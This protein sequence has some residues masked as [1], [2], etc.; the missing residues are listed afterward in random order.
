[1]NTPMPPPP[2]PAPRPSG[3]PMPPGQPLPPTRAE[4]TFNSALQRPAAERPAYLAEACADDDALHAEVMA[5]LQAH[6]AADDFMKTDAPLS[7]EIEEQL[8]RLKPEAEG[9]RIGRYKLL[10]EIGEGG[11]GTVWMAEQMEPV[12]RRVALK[13]IKMGMDTREVI[14]RFESERQALAMMDHPNIA[15][16]FDAG[17]TQY[18]RPF[19]VM[20]LVK[21]VTITQYCDGAQL[22]TRERLAL[23][24]DVCSAINHAHQKGVIHRD[25]K[26]SNV[27]VTLHGDKPV[28][29]VI[30]FG[31]AK[32]TQGKLTDKTL[33]TRF[34]Q[35]I[36]T[37]V[38]MSP[39]QASTSGLDIDT[40]SDIYALGVLLY[41]LL[42]GRPPFDA[43]SLV[44]AG[45][46]EMRRIIREVEP[47]KPSSRISTMVGDERTQ[48][49]KA[50]HVEPEKLHRLVEPDLDWIVMK[51]I[52]KDRTRRYETANAF[53]QDV[54][55]FLADEP[56]S[57]TPPSVGYRLR[58]FARRNRRALASGATVG[59]ALLLGLSVAGW[60]WLDSAWQKASQL[61][62]VEQRASTMITDGERE[63]E[64]NRQVPFED[65]ANFLRAEEMVRRL[66][67]LVGFE[68]ASAELRA[69]KAGLVA[70][71][72]REGHD[73]ALV[74]RIEEALMKS[75]KGLGSPKT[76]KAQD[77]AEAFQKSELNPEAL[78][79][80]AIVAGITERREALRERLVA[81]LVDWADSLAETEPE[82][83][84]RLNAIIDRCDSD[85]WRQSLRKAVSAGDGAALDA[86]VDS[87]E[88]SRQP[89]MT[90]LRL[91]SAL[92]K[93]QL[94]GGVEKLLRRAQREAPGSF[95]TNFSL[96]MALAGAIDRPEGS[97]LSD[98]FIVNRVELGQSVPGMGANPQAAR[99]EIT[100]AIG[101]LRAAAAARP[102]AG[103]AWLTLGLTLSS[104]AHW[105]EAIASYRR[106]LELVPGD[107]NAYLA[108]GTAFLG[109][110][111]P[112]E[113]V[114]ALRKAV[115]LGE[116]GAF[117]QVQLG[118]ALAQIGQDDE[119][120]A[121]LQKGLEQGSEIEG[122]EIKVKGI[123]MRRGDSGQALGVA[124]YYLGVLQFGRSD[125]DRAAVSLRLA[126]EAVPD[127]ATPHMLLGLVLFQK[128]EAAAAIPSFR[129]AIELAPDV[130][131][132]HNGLGVS[133]MQTGD[134]KAATSSLRQA[135]KLDPS[136]A[137]AQS[138]LG[139]ALLQTGNAD[140]AFSVLKKAVELNPASAMAWSNLGAA[141]DRR[142]NLE[143]AAAAFRKSIA[144]DPNYAEAQRNLAKVLAR[145]GKRDE[146]TEMSRPLPEADWGDAT[147][148]LELGRALGKQSK[149]EEAAAA[150]RRAIELDPKMVNAHRG[151]GLALLNSGHLEEAV[152]AL[153]ETIQLDPKMADAQMM[154]GG[155]LLDL[156]KFAEAGE[157]CHAAIALDPKSGPAHA[158]L[159]SALSKLGNFDEAVTACRTAIQ[160]GG[161]PPLTHSVLGF[162]LS[163]QG[164]F[165]EA[166]EALRASI[167]L[168]PKQATAHSRLAG[169]LSRLGKFD[170][171]VA[172][173][174]QALTLDPEFSL[175][176]TYS[177]QFTTGG[178]DLAQDPGM[179]EEVLKLSRAVH[180]PEHPDTIGAMT[181]LAMAYGEKGRLAEAIPLQE[182][183]LTI[184]RRVLPKNHP[185]LAIAMASLADLYHESGRNAEAVRLYE[186]LVALRRKV[187]GA[188]H[189]DTLRATHNLGAVH[190]KAGRL[191]ELTKVIAEQIE[192]L[193]RAGIEPDSEPALTLQNQLTARA[194][195][196]TKAPPQEDAI[197]RYYAD[198]QE[199][200]RQFTVHVYMITLPLAGQDE[201]KV[202]Q[203]KKAEDLRR[204]IV[205]GTPFAEVAREFS[206]DRSAKA[207]GDCGLVA[208]GEY[209][210]DL[211]KLIFSMKPG[212]LA[213]QEDEKYLR[214]LKVED[215]VDGAI[216]PLEN[217]REKIKTILKV[218]QRAKLLEQWKEAARQAVD[219]QEKTE[220]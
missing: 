31:I 206:E 161:V 44:S 51:A 19:F 210:P 75:M 4:A 88:I 151:L 68:Q 173:Y 144:A 38:Y 18:G 2:P 14:A 11:F 211:D 131:A 205:E 93:K 190:F 196:L 98:T 204:K 20:E 128:D 41:E 146:A 114:A 73:R 178:W 179:Y 124:R 72:A 171:A 165:D 163:K 59:A 140:E 50:R 180:G 182:Q 103:R 220:Q 176:T 129:R 158:I 109:R 90:V 188:A 34:E 17:A 117:V 159:G 149:F 106:G 218:Q 21:G 152:T 85:P 42:T 135:I 82:K 162:A 61:A 54:V 105:D 86:L 102:D 8:A 198:H 81:G 217:A 177:E 84:A 197:T 1:M 91:S 47:V 69:R 199:S 3:P 37:P 203:R 15:K 112:K 126:I 100:E 56:V 187:L 194:A 65:D 116:G 164:K 67:S 118:T 189:P 43:K 174:Q 134:F 170:E 123:K 212:S 214:I 33:F 35:F 157:A 40:R 142:G 172:S 148:Q 192:Y 127:F 130:A 99:P 121:F 209:R 181:N 36:G 24:G 77:V 22:G 52:E 132:A 160:L 71:V 147:A 184:K 53:A 154:L 110:K 10:Q 29:K 219:A 92:R 145:L 107:A 143:E 125:F 193:R 185:F 70:S 186:E 156:G 79:A 5:L 207:G 113:A 45:Y 213:I 97:D 78:S 49:A 23:F 57:A 96:G 13:I 133:L 202:A 9:E 111:K 120:L 74:A 175:L 168:D 60:V 167:Q 83:A 191:D 138:N 141:F 137:Q 153:R 16:V 6:D 104:G 108:L 80:D 87:P 200:F 94:G 32:A 30:D 208:R 89:T 166:V 55:R 62:A 63:M 25:I 7:P 95:W 136:D 66:D 64:L 115:E 183:S 27:M 28:V 216:E 169:A 122:E 215:R 12:S 150:F 48:L 101:F 155:V 46:E 195:E 39:E 119:A 76:T 201:A 58:K 139:I 26:P